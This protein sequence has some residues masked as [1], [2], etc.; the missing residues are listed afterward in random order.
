MNI[1][2]LMEWLWVTHDQKKGISPVVLVSGVPLVLPPSSQLVW[3]V[4]C[5]QEQGR[6][7]L[8]EDGLF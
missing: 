7:F 8:S 1:R 2:E 4:V 3:G 6:R 5:T